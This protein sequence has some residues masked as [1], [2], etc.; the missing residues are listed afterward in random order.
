MLIDVFLCRQSDATRSYASCNSSS[1]DAS[2][3][4]HWISLSFMDPKNKPCTF[5]RPPDGPWRSSAISS[6]NPDL[7]NAGAQQQRSRRS[8]LKTPD[9]TNQWIYIFSF[10]IDG[11]QLQW[12]SIGV[13]ACIS[14]IEEWSRVLFLVGATCNQRCAIG[15][16]LYEKKSTTNPTSRD[17]FGSGGHK[18]YAQDCPTNESL[19]QTISFRIERKQCTSLE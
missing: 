18:I 6:T 10:K 4:S 8:R 12:Y 15:T 13:C 19:N 9:V 3:S 11:L 7:N 17:S 2:T 5:C 1:S 14:A 16:R